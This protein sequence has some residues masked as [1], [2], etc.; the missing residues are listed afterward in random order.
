MPGQLR[1]LQAGEQGD[2]TSWLQ[3]DLSCKVGQ[4]C[5]NHEQRPRLG[6]LLTAW[7]PNLRTAA[8]AWHRKVDQSCQIFMPQILQQAPSPASCG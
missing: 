7:A 5:A 4:H 8:P 1:S 3:P 6:G 2:G